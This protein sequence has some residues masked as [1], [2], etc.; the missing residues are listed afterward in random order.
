MSQQLGIVIIIDVKSALKEN[1]LENNIYMFDNNKWLGSQGEGSKELISA[2]HQ[3]GYNGQ[4]MNWISCAV[5]SLPITIPKTFFMK[6]NNVSVLTAKNSQM[7]L[8]ITGKELDLSKINADELLNIQRPM[9][10]ILEI[11][12]EAVDK[13]IIVPAIY[14]SPDPLSQG[15]YWSAVVS[16]SQKGKYTYT[17]YFKLYYPCKE[18][19]NGTIRWKYKIMRHDAYIYITNSSL[20][21]G[22]CGNDKILP[23]Y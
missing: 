23:A 20:V 12:G 4:I 2:I 22:F 16:M 19:E 18:E 13:G 1:N 5:G 3:D 14:G 8:D 17:L 6:K 10:E 9:P 7:Q 21:N 11:K 15:L